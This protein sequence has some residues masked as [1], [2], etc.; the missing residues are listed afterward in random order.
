M[1]KGFFAPFFVIL[2]CSLQ[3]S[4]SAQEMTLVRP[5]VIRVNVM[6]DTIFRY[7]VNTNQIYECGLDTLPQMKF[8][9]KI[10]RMSPDT[11]LVSLAMDRRIFCSMTSV[12]WDNLG[13]AGQENF[14][15][16]LRKKN[17]LNDSAQ[18]LFTKGKNDFYDPKAVIPQ[19]DR[20]IPIF[21]QQGV[22]P[23]YAQAILLIESPG[24]TEKSGAGANGAFQLMKSVA[25]QMGLKVNKTVDERKDFDKSA[26]A[27]SRL[28]QTVC[29]PYA[30]SMLDKRGLCYN[31]NDLWFRLLVMHVY[32]AG[33]G[34]VEKALVVINP[35]EGGIEL[36]KTLWHTTAGQ[37]GRSSQ[38]YSQVAVAA[39]LE[40]DEVYGRTDEIRKT[41]LT[42]QL[43][44]N[45]TPH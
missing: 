7:M 42:P 11:G 16:S 31:E 43:F 36:I 12:A 26:W 37:F 34:N 21:V 33:A 2:I 40:L 20:A 32:H 8:W 45:T 23:F 27:A 29:I 28:L 13:E 3:I 18:V 10:M 24:K 30:K 39:L 14:R 41:C 15:D 4:L 35:T 22:D 1:R 17:L 44:E 6:N 25:I 5:D 19:I 38:T 9:R